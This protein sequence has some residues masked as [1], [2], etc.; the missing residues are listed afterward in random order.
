MKTP[1]QLHIPVLLDLV[2]RY[3][4]PEKD[5]SYLDL[6]AGYGGHASEILKITQ[7]PERAVLVDRDKNAIRELRNQCGLANAEF[8]HSDF[9][10]AATKL[11]DSGRKFNLILMDLGVSSAQ[12]DQAERGFS[13]RYDAELDMRMDESQSLTAAEVVN[14]SSEKLL[15]EIIAKYGEETPK[16]ARRIARAIRL[17]RPIK[18]TKQLAETVAKVH[19]GK[20]KIHPATRTFQAVRIVVNDELRQLSEA[21]PIAQQ[22]LEKG[23]RL[24][25]ISFHSLEDSIV[26]NYF[27]EQ[28]RAGYEATLG[29]ITKK[30]IIASQNE[31]VYN[32]RSRSAKLRVAVKK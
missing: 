15:S 5:E 21:L 27:N 23:G 31:I 17:N 30:P 13:F 2:V 19:H 25:V 22:L 3:L 28:S 29:L 4:A 6:T 12:L 7:N 8:M 24:G 20:G 9:L 10:A 11:L 1:Q 16:A 18:T 32:P 26:K 14:R